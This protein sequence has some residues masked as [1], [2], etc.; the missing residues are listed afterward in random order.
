MSG[1][2]THVTPEQVEAYWH[3]LPAERA[4]KGKPRWPLAPGRHEAHASRIHLTAYVSDGRW[5]ADCKGGPTEECRGGI[6]CWPQHGKGCCLDCGTVYLIDF[7]PADELEAG[8]EALLQRPSGNRHWA[9]QRGETAS[10][11]KVDNLE[12]GVSPVGTGDWRD[13]VAEETGVSREL[14]ELVERSI[15]KRQ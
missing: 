6:A 14:V 4:A 9:I 12:H 13:E 1:P 3:K 8:V 15:G 11:L 5:V 10:D 2:E 7:P